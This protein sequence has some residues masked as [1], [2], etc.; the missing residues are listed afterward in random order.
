MKEIPNFYAVEG[1]DGVGKSTVIDLMRQKGCLVFKTPPPEFEFVR[2]SFDQKDTRVRFLYYLLGVV[3]AQKEIEKASLNKVKVCDRYLLTTVAAHEAMGLEAP[4][5]TMMK[6]IFNCIRRPTSTFLLTADDKVRRERLFGRG[7]NTSDIE[8]FS[9]NEDLLKGYQKW[10]QVLGHRLVEV[11]TS[12]LDPI[13]VVESLDQ[14][15]REG[16]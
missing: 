5:I 1:L 4:F 16:E 13:G 12:N 11:D 9:I 15:I 8:N 10:S 7:V 14:I 6:P 3:Y 2:K